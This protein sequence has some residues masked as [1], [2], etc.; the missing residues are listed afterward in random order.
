MYAVKHALK[1]QWGISTG[2]M[3]VATPE[4]HTSN[5]GTYVIHTRK[6]VYGTGVL[7]K[8]MREWIDV[9]GS[10]MILKRQNLVSRET[11]A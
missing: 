7:S 4:G 6:N 10:K 8:G 5:I 2:R 1:H 3:Y 9:V 11:E